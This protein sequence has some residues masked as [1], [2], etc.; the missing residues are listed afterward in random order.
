MKNRAVI[1][2]E[3]FSAPVLPVI[4]SEKAKGEMVRKGIHLLIALTPNFA[5]ISKPVTLFLLVFGMALYT[6]LEFLMLRGLQIPLFSRIIGAANRERDKGKFA[7]G[8]LTLA[9]GAALSLVLFNRDCAFIAIYALA[10]GDGFASLVGRIFGRTRPRIFAGKSVEGSLT[11]FLAVYL[12]VLSLSRD[13]RLSCITALTA[14]II[15][16]LPLKDW[17]NIIIPLSTG[18]TAALVMGFYF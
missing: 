11:C 8:P 15:E 1:V 14:T 5:L 13:W 6:A 3:L 4:P 10:F 12:S 18:Y 2:W 17:D 16:A 7:L 9:A